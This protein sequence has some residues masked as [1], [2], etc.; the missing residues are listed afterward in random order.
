MVHIQWSLLRGSRPFFTGCLL[1]CVVDG[2]MNDTQREEINSENAS[3]K[4]M[5]GTDR[6]LSSVEDLSVDGLVIEQLAIRKIVGEKV[7]QFSIHLFIFVCSLIVSEYLRR[8]CRSVKKKEQSPV[9]PP[10]IPRQIWTY[11]HDEDLPML[12]RDCIKGWQRHNPHYHITLVHRK[13]LHQYISV[14]LPSNFDQLTYQRQSDWARLVL[15][16]EHGGLWIDAS[17][18][19]TGSLDFVRDER[20]VD[21]SEGFAFYLDLFTKDS[22]FPMLESWFIATIPRGQLVTA[23]FT[24]FDFATRTWGNDGQKYLDHLVDTYGQA[25]YAIL[26]QNIVEPDYLTIHIAAQKVMRMDGVKPLSAH[27]AEQSPYKPYEV[28]VEHCQ[29]DSE[30]FA[31][32]VLLPWTTPLPR[33]IKIRGEERAALIALLKSGHEIDRTSLYYQSVHGLHIAQ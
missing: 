23:W 3:T 5:T 17:F 15:L 31:K 18:L 26:L 1:L 25:Q 4:I 24:E 33:L 20:K 28:L 27:A 8:H 22:S 32:K 10:E 21:G 13:T 7:V 29:W 12:I 2:S 16:M 14:S 9:D 11:W 6:Y 30:R 19:I